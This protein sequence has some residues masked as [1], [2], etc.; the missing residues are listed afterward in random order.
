MPSLAASL[1]ET[2]LEVVVVEFLRKFIV[3]ARLDLL[4][5]EFTT[6]EHGNSILLLVDL[7]L[8]HD[9]VVRAEANRMS[10]FVRRLLL[11]I[12]QLGR[13]DEIALLERV[14]LDAVTDEQVMG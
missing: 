6:E 10:D 14:L 1:S 3:T 13:R 8:L 7:H 12:R 11:L 4:L 5:L 2:N 9:C